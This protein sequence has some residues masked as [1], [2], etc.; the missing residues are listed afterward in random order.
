MKIFASA[1]LAVVAPL[2]AASQTIKTQ[3]SFPQPVSGIAADPISNHIYVVVPSFGGPSDTL[4]VINGASDTVTHN[5]TV[6]TGAYLPAVNIFTHHIYIASCNIFAD[7]VPCFVTVVNEEKKKVV[8]N[9]P[10][11]TTPGNGLQ[12]ITV[13][14]VTN[15]I[16]VAN[17]SDN[18]I[19]IIDGWTNTV[20][21][22]ISLNG[23]SPFGLTINPFNDRLY[24]PLGNSQVDV[25]SARQ[26]KILATATFG[27]NT[28]FAA[29]NWHT[30]HVFVTDSVFGP[31]TTGVLDRNG[32]LL[33]SVPVG[34]TPFG[35][36]VDPITNLA[37]VTSTALNNVTVIN[38]WNNTVAATV[39]G[40][41]ANFVAVNI[42]TEKVYLAGDNGVTVMTEK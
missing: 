23:E 32:A 17:A 7:P 19:D 14:P 18:V 3:I 33:A 22:T 2:T 42:V 5:I 21:G 1:V 24:V 26:K 40:I 36:D 15:R 9:I 35:L 34:D 13:D 4:A 31:S 25:I 8:A 41:Q 16:Y 37:F 30:G 39:P 29:V 27:S 11:T 6:P 38:G 20:T 12:G 10:I 28:A